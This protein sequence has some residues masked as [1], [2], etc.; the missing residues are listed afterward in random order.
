VREPGVDRQAVGSRLRF[1][2][3]LE[4]LG[5]PQRDPGCSGVV[6]RGV[7][8]GLRRLVGVLR[9]GGDDELRLAT[10]EPDVDDGV[11]EPGRNLRSGRGQ[12]L[13]QREPDRGVE[14]L[15]K[16]PGHLNDV[17]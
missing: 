16:L 5:E 11:V 12:Y 17:V 15:G 1:D 3:R 8:G 13:E 2:P 10:A 9:H 7:S 14:S 4:R 6:G